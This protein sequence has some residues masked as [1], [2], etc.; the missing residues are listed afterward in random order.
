M[1]KTNLLHPEI[2]EALASGGHGTKVLV[3][4]SNYPFATKC[5]PNARIVFLNLSPGLLNATDVLEVLVQNIPIEAA[6][7]IRPESGVLAPIVA[8]FQKIIGPEP[9]VEALSRHGFYDAV[10]SDDCGLVIAT[11][12]QRTF[13]CIVLTI[14]V[15]EPT[16]D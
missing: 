11:G 15:V 14:G 6:H 5:G 12:E 8:E 7:V 3:A 9:K 13:A 10:K 4:D 1:L 16:K 2:L